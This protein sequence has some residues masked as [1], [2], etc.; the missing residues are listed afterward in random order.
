MFL[1]YMSNAHEIFEK[2]FVSLWAAKQR[3]AWDSRYSLIFQSL[4]QALH[5]TL[6][7]FSSYHSHQSP[8]TLSEASS[9]FRSKRPANHTLEKRQVRC[10]ETL[11]M[12]RLERHWHWTRSWWELN[13]GFDRP[14]WRAAQDFLA[15]LEKNG[16]LTM[17]G[18]PLKRNL[19][20]L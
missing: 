11:G 19:M 18:M 5:P 2:L 3:D 1:S 14:N 7:M 10:F 17:V 6:Q 9:R 15:F 8:I 16:K 20:G 12:C 4:G 13:K